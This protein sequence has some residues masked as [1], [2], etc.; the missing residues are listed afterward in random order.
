MQ[1]AIYLFARICLALLS[2]DKKKKILF[3][4]IEDIIVK[5]KKFGK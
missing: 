4:K 3:R 5:K 2:Y 1:F